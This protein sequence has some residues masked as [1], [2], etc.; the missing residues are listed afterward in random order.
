MFYMKYYL[1]R[2]NNGLNIHIAMWLDPLQG[3][4]SWEKKEIHDRCVY[5]YMCVCV[6]CDVPKLK[7]C[8]YNI[9]CQLHLNNKKSVSVRIHKNNRCILNKMY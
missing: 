5:T 1:A 2:K 8:K 3:S 9:I 6:C 4:T 7:I